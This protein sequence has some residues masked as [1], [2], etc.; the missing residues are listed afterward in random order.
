[1]GFRYRAWIL[2]AVLFISSYKLVSTL[3]YN[4][5]NGMETEKSTRTEHAP[6][7]I[8]AGVTYHGHH[9]SRSHGIRQWRSTHGLDQTGNR[10]S[11][12]NVE[13]F[14]VNLCE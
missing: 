2:P 11:A 7:S 12:G 6:A 4:I 10:K 9:N 8:A 1:M 5:S 3:D 13:E 14:H